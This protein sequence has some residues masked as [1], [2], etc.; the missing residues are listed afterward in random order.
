MQSSVKSVLTAHT[1]HTHTHTTSTGW[2]Q[3][4]NLIQQLDYHKTTEMQCFKDEVFGPVLSIGRFETEE[5]ALAI[6]N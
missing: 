5:D 6:G 2:V 3:K 1:T 4:L